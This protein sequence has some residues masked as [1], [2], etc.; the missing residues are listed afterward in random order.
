MKIGLKYSEAGLHSDNNLPVINDGNWNKN[1]KFPTDLGKIIKSEGISTDD[2]DSI[3]V[4]YKFIP[5]GLLICLIKRTKIGSR[6]TNSN[7]ALWIFVPSEMEIEPSQIVE[8]IEETGKMLSNPLTF[9]NE[10]NFRKALPQIYKKEFPV[11]PEKCDFIGNMEG[12]KLAVLECHSPLTLETVFD[13]GY[14]SQFAEYGLIAINSVGFNNTPLPTLDATTFVKASSLTEEEEQNIEPQP[15]YREEE[16]PATVENHENYEETLAAATGLG[17]SPETSNEPYEAQP[18]PQE[19]NIPLPDA[20]EQASG[21]P[22]MPHNVSQQKLSIGHPVANPNVKFSSPNP[23]TGHPQMTPPPIPGHPTQES[24][25]PIE[26]E[27]PQQEITQ[28]P[29]SHTEA[30]RINPHVATEQPYSQPASFAPYEDSPKKKN[31][32]LIIGLIIGLALVIGGSLVYYFLAGS[33]GQKSSVESNEFYSEGDVYSA[34]DDLHHSRRRSTRRGQNN[35]KSSRA[36]FFPNGK[37][38]WEGKVYTGSGVFDITLDVNN[39]NGSFSNC[40][41]TN[42]TYGATIELNGYTNRDGSIEFYGEKRGQDLQIKITDASNGTLYGTYEV[43]TSSKAV[44]YDVTFTR[45]G[46]TS[47]GR[48]YSSYNESSSS[49]NSTSGVINLKGKIDGK[50]AVHVRLNLSSGTGSY[51]YDKYGSSNTMTLKIT[52]SSPDYFVMEEYNKKGEYCGEWR[53]TLANGVYS[54]TGSFVGGEM[55]FYLS[56]Y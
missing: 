41:Y 45:K 28:N 27:Y 13:F 48:S 4:A 30:P 52:N 18:H 8:I 38:E 39:Q 35:T 21:Q 22:L 32:A 29:E 16:T 40:L 54:G 3:G 33:G 44:S 20:A 5:E 9:A 42:P 2:A 15:E 25:A 51:Y 31:K 46:G 55:P 1:S 24:F 47:S 34:D 19:T 17:A 50:Y 37:S 56:E 49:K 36:D 53:G 26:E 6:V 43:E 7:Q 14:Q 10:D 12:S 11:N 23:E